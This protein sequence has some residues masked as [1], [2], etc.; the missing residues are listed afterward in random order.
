MI[1]TTHQFHFEVGCRR[2]KRVESGSAPLQPLAG[3]VPRVSK[4]M[5]LAIRLEI[6]IRTGQ[7]T[8]QAELARLSH[9]S[10]ARLTQI[11]NLLQLAPDIQEQVLFL[12]TT[13][14]G[15]DPITERDLRPIASIVKWSTQRA[16]WKRILKTNAAT[17]PAQ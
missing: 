13:Q 6:L 7:V 16:E 4:L 3:R 8:D 11:T 10:R 15:R 12:P 1:T 17:V 9:V 5:A 14:S 2:S